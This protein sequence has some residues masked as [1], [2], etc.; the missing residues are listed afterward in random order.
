M[1]LNDLFA[2]GKTKTGTAIPAEA[3][4]EQAGQ[5]LG[6]DPLAVVGNRDRRKSGL[7]F[8][9]NSQQYGTAPCMAVGVC[10]Q[11]DQRLKNAARVH[12]Q[13]DFFGTRGIG[14]AGLL[15]CDVTITG[16]TVTSITNKSSAIGR[17]NRS[18]STGGSVVITGGTVT[19]QSY[20]NNY[21]GIDCSNLATG[22]ITITGGTVTASG[23]LDGFGIRGS[24]AGTGTIT[25]SGGTVTATGGPGGMP[26]AGGTGGVGGSG[27]CASSTGTG[28]I[29]ISGGTV[30]AGGG[31]CDLGHGILSA[32][33]TLSITGTAMVF[34]QSNNCTTPPTTTHTNTT[35]PI[36]TTE[37]YGTGIC[38]PE[39]WT[40]DFG[41]YLRTC[42]LSYDVNGGEG[43]AP[44][45]V[46]RLYGTEV[47][48]PD[49][50]GLSRENYHFDGWNTAADG[51]GD[52]CAAD[53]AYT[54]G[55]DTTLYA[56]WTGNPSTVY[57]F[58]PRTLTDSATDITVSGNSILSSAQ[59]IVSPL[60]PHLQD[61]CAACNAILEAQKRGDLILGFDIELTQDLISGLTIS[62][63]VGS[64]YDGQIVTIL[65]CVNGKLE[66]HTATVNN[67]KATITVTSLSPFAVMR[68]QFVPDDTTDIPQTGDAAT[69]LGF[70]MLTL[71]ALCAGSLILKRR[72]A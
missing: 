1:F 29:E 53:S 8:L 12:A 6:I 48:L 30:Y 58:V 35:Y 62:I 55:A 32:V 14:G 7:N 31:M 65:H 41:A 46:T 2:D 52:S 34:L 19:A 61:G 23:A 10:D 57:E 68:G 13:Q 9:S 27:I 70:I 17:S 69:P 49:G 26:L 38:V 43:T 56:T 28:S 11:I 18:V 33:D 54:M 60:K 4:L 51:S 64:K 42:T 50:S 72:R 44:G 40:G 59:L 37:V 15:G 21:A 20:G 22:T 45:S 71:A 67:G 3:T 66:T 24:S 5:P 16:G 47:T 36:G 39:T 25:I 63:P